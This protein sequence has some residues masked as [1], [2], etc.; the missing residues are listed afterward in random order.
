MPD[1]EHD[2]LERELREVC[3]RI[4]YP[5]TPDVSRTVKLRLEAA[6]PTRRR[7]LPR[8][9]ARSGWAAAAAAAVLLSLSIIS[10]AVRSNFSDILSAGASGGAGGS[11]QAG[12]GDEAGV[13]PA[14]YAT[15]DVPPPADEF[16]EP[17]PEAAA[18]GSLA[19]PSPGEALG[20]GEI[21]LPSKASAMV[22]GLLLPEPGLV[23]GPGVVHMA[24]PDEADGVVV[25][26]GPEPGLPPFGGT[27]AGLVL[28]ESSGDPRDVYPLTD[29]AYEA[30]EEVDVGGV[31]GYWIPDG[32]SLRPQPGDSGSLPGGALVWER[33]DVAL[34]MRADVTKQEA[35]EIAETVR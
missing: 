4:D 26:F 1:R 24:G 28:V 35:V 22:G 8:M 31:R 25:V 14:E 9:L 32:R 34:L 6:E 30:S 11:G 10:P 33:G 12:S 17:S 5:L 21:I 7:R 23:D 16:T 19:A 3:S 13:S 27:D 20:F 2:G 29:G 15:E 18:G